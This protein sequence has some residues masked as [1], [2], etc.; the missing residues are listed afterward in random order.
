MP[1]LTALNQ[2][3]VLGTTLTSDLAR[4]KAQV[5][6]NS[7]RRDCRGTA[8]MASSKKSVKSNPPRHNSPA[9]GPRELSRPG[10]QA[11]CGTHMVLAGTGDSRVADGVSRP[12]E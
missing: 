1:G 3:R 7:R 10:E 6:S 5:G 4:R 12:R 11:G 8:S 2:R 9:H